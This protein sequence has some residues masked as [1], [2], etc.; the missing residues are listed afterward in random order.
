MKTLLDGHK[1]VV[2]AS[3]L[4]QLFSSSISIDWYQKS[5]IIEFYRLLARSRLQDSLAFFRSFALAESLAQANRLSVYRLTTPDVGNDYHPCMQQIRLWK[6]VGKNNNNKIISL[7][8]HFIL[9]NLT[10]EQ[11][12]V[13]LVVVT[14]T[15]YFITEI[16]KLLGFTLVNVK[17]LHGYQNN[18]LCPWASRSLIYIHSSTLNI[19]T[20]FMVFMTHISST[21]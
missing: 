13:Q 5:I 19:N 16:I 6:L 11:S 3:V 17:D 15:P 12:L 2:N 18:L 9:N 1:G 10:Y 7:R 21:K 4:T 8:I 20:I 14:W